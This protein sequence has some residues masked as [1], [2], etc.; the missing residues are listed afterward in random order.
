MKKSMLLRDMVI[1]MSF[2]V[3]GA[4]FGSSQVL[5]RPH[6]HSSTDGSGQ[7]NTNQ[8]IKTYK[9]GVPTPKT[10]VIEAATGNII[11]AGNIIG[12]NIVAAL[13]SYQK[14]NCAVITTGPITLS[15][16]Q[17]IDGVAGATGTR[18]LVSGQ[19]A[20][21]AEQNGIYTMAAGAWARSTDM[22]TTAEAVENSWAIVTSGTVYA[23]T[24]WYVSTAP[25]TLGTDDLLWSQLGGSAS[26]LY[27]KLDTS[28][29]PL[30]GNVTVSKATPV[31]KLNDTVRDSYVQVTKSNT[32]HEAKM[33]NVT[34][35]TTGTMPYAAN[36]HEDNADY[37]NAGDIAGIDGAAAL[38]IA[39]WVK[40]PFT[41]GSNEFA[42]IS[43][44]VRGMAGVGPSFVAGIETIGGGA[45]MHSMW[46]GDVGGGLAPE[47]YCNLAIVAGAWD[48]VVW[49]YNGAGVGNANRL[50]MY[51]NGVACPLMAYTGTIPETIP[52]S[53]TTPVIIG[54][55][56]PGFF[57]AYK[58]AIDEVSLYSAAWAA[59]DVTTGYAA[60][61]G[62]YGLLA[63][64]NLIAGWHLDEPLATDNAADYGAGAI[65]ATRNGSIPKIIST[66]ALGGGAPTTT[67]VDLVDSIEAAVAGDGDGITTFGDS[68][69]RTIVDG[70]SIDFNIGGVQAADIDTSGNL[71][72]TGS[73][74]SSGGDVQAF[75]DIISGDDV[76]VAT[77]GKFI[78]DSPADAKYITYSA[79]H[80]DYVGAAHFSSTL[81][82]DDD[83]TTGTGIGAGGVTITAVGEVSAYSDVISTTGDITTSDGRVT[84]S[85]L[86]KAAFQGTATSTYHTADLRHGLG[87]GDVIHITT[88]SGTGKDFYGLNGH[89]TIDKTGVLSTDAQITSTYP[90]ISGSPFSITSTTVNTNLNADL[91]DGYHA[92]NTTGAVPIS[93]TT[94]NTDLNAD[95]LDGSHESAFF[96]LADDETVTG[97]PAFN[98]GLT[99]ATAPF[100]V[101]STF[102]VTSLNADLLDGNHAA[103]FAPAGSYVSKTGDQMTGPLRITSSVGTLGWFDATGQNAATSTVVITSNNSNSTTAN[104]ALYLGITGKLTTGL[105]SYIN[106]T[107]AAASAI[108]G[109][110]NGIVNTSAVVGVSQRAGRGV[111]GGNTST[112]ATSPWVDGVTGISSG[113]AGYF[114]C[115]TAADHPSPCL[116]VN[117]N[118][119]GRLF[120]AYNDEAMLAEISNDGTIMATATIKSKST[121]AFHAPTANSYFNFGATQGTGGYGFYDNA[122]T[123]QWKNS[124][125]DWADIAAPLWTRSAL[126]SSGYKLVPFTAAS[127]TVQL[128]SYATSAAIIN[129]YS[130]A[131]T[132]Y[133]PAI[134]IKFDGVYNVAGVT[135]CGY[136]GALCVRTTQAASVGEHIDVPHGGVFAQHTEGNSKTE[137]RHTFSTDGASWGTNDVIASSPNGTTIKY[138]MGANHA[139]TH[140]LELNNA[141]GASALYLASSDGFA[142]DSTG[143]VVAFT[144][145]NRAN[146]PVIYSVISSEAADPTT[147]AEDGKL[148]F[149]VTQAGNP[150]ITYVELDALAGDIELFKPVVASSTIKSNGYMVPVWDDTS[151]QGRWAITSQDITAQ[152][153]G[154]F[155]FTNVFASD[156]ISC[157]C[158]V[159]STTPGTTT[160]C[161]IAALS[162]ANCQ[163]ILGAAI[164]GKVYL[165]AFGRD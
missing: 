24:T 17:T 73:I 70:K 55:A 128:H 136:G 150:A 158:S 131:L 132:N 44:G 98:G 161:G 124:A 14:T 157:I 96:K 141:G 6:H 152:S 81:D 111:S 105:N 144:D 143:G 88:N 116:V 57:S 65:T 86:D 126:T 160:S 49:V 162:T 146:A 159:Y 82:T 103:A 22:D 26:A 140:M 123:L 30:T 87:A 31:L 20:A 52:D 47:A 42:A 155:T 137:I 35:V 75:D 154:T 71:T 63:D 84:A 72:A 147:G 69:A 61:A 164:T 149:N 129:T 133:E 114:H 106:N 59:G 148:K 79:T 117:D 92:A 113:A 41:P 66:K 109:L 102:L 151:S 68:T 33:I 56:S 27:Y 8:D 15:G 36:F 138:W 118:G 153:T 62:R 77:G 58:E 11:C 120:A 10:C 99:G 3:L 110:T 80:V 37:Y 93:N 7:I 19:A 91:L 16:I 34:S 121:N 101:D 134:K 54:N 45:L 119:T 107:L 135:D 40:V 25:A 163:W 50:K 29:G 4:S 53:T 100:T 115:G 51:R 95:M 78:L 48:Y 21:D 122:G 90:T 145:Y 23:N 108:S 46:M 156:T 83:L 165:Q 13:P 2:M 130:Q 125:G 67:T 5:W 142:T 18:V 43:K 64:A 139:D 39:Y 104:N 28:N 12:S 94:V 38:T 32:S 89:L 76:R 60:G 97:V 85:A 74:D 112:A 1:V 127:D 9:S